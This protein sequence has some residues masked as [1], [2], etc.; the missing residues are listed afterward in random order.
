MSTMVESPKVSSIALAASSNFR[1]RGAKMD[2]MQSQWTFLKSADRFDRID[3]LQ[4]GQ[5]NWRDDQ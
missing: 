1:W 2:S 4:N 5:F 3:N